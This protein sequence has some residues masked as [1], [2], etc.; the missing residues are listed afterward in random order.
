MNATVAN[1]YQ[2]VGMRM[3]AMIMG[4]KLR[5]WLEGLDNDQLAFFYTDAGNLFTR[6]GLA[7]NLLQRLVSA[8]IGSL[9]A[10]AEAISGNMALYMYFAELTYGI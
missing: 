10:F 6:Y 5:D 4:T 1:D 7:A 9:E 2:I 3:K 8:D